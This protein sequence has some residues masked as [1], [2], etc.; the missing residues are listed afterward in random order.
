M[1]SFKV[2]CSILIEQTFKRIP[3]STLLLVYEDQRAFLQ[4]EGFNRE[5]VKQ[6]TYQKFGEQLSIYEYGHLQY[7]VSFQ[8]QFDISQFIA[9]SGFHAYSE[10]SAQVEQLSVNIE[11]LIEIIQHEGFSEYVDSVE[12]VLL[13]LMK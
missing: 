10:Q 5:L 2:N 7:M 4:F 6:S 1:T 8:S 3:T 13:S 12:R 9:L 11:D